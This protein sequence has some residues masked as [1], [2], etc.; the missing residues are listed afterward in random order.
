VPAA[1]RTAEN[2]RDEADDFAR[3]ESRPFEWSYEWAWLP[4]LAE[5]LH[6]CDAPDAKWRSRALRPA[7]V[8]ALKTPIASHT[9]MLA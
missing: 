1:H 5:A 8:T 4:K 9:S 7:P 2:L 6:G 3:K